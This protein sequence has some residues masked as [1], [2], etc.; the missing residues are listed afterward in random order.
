M[1]LPDDKF[2]N[3]NADITATLERANKNFRV[4]Y[5]TLSKLLGRLQHT[6]YV[7]PEGCHFLNRLRT[8]NMRAEAHGSTRLDKETRK[9]LVLWKSFLDKAHKG[10]N[11][12][13]LVTR[14]PDHIIRTDA[15]EHGLGGYS[16]TTGRA[17][18]YK[19]P[20][21]AKNQKSINFLEFLAC[22]TGIIVSLYE[23]KEHPATA[24]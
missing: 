19:L 6:T 9:D 1:S 5:D 15:C 2:E 12:N 4:N 10:I 24:T 13:L 14:E 18:R 22:I 8:A 23:V 7:L 17:W 11:I 3:W 21:D 16:L 20:P